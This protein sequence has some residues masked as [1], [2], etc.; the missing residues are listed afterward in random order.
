VQLPVRIRVVRAHTR[1]PGVCP[2]AIAARAQR[3]HDREAADLLRQYRPD[4]LIDSGCP[5]LDE[6]LKF[7][8]DRQR[9][10]GGKRRSLVDEFVSLIAGSARL[11]AAS[12]RSTISS[13]F[14]S[15]RWTRCTSPEPGTLD[16]HGPPPLLNSEQQA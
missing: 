8:S 11:G 2:A 9:R 5:P 4:F 16:M 7:L 14:S 6:G 12:D 15:S 1:E 10:R 13:S 3:S